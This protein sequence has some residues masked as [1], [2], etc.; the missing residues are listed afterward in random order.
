MNKHKAQMKDIMDNKFKLSQDLF[1][2]EQDIWNMA[3]KLA[4]ET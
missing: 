3:C 1:L 2:S 4:K